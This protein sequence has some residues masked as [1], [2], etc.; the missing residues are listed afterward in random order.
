MK[1]N[2]AML[3]ALL[4]HAWTVGDKSTGTTDPGVTSKC[5]RWANNM[6]SDDSCKALESKFDVDFLQLHE[7]VS[8]PS[9]TGPWPSSGS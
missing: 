8:H 5:T 1:L 4:A 9:L 2:T 7:R 6:A 3:A